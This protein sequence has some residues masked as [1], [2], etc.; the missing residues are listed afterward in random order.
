V[1]LAQLALNFHAKTDQFKNFF[2]VNQFFHL[3]HELQIR[4]LRNELHKLSR[5]SY[6]VSLRVS[7]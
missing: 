7:S 2:L 1:A 3:R 5:I 4:G 6:R